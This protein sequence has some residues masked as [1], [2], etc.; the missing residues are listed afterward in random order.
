M[1]GLTKS[2][3][4]LAT[5]QVGGPGL[6]EDQMTRMNKLKT[7]LTVIMGLVL[8]APAGAAASSVTISDTTLVR[9]YIG[10]APG[11]G[12]GYDKNLLYDVIGIKGGVSGQANGFDTSAVTVDWYD[13]NSLKFTIYTNFPQ[14]GGAAI[15]S[16]DPAI[17][18]DLVLRDKNGNLYGI[19]LTTHGDFT[20]GGLY[21]NAGFLNANAQSPLNNGSWVYGGAYS[22]DGTVPATGTNLSPT[23]LDAGTLLANVSL[24]WVLNTD[25]NNA[26]T[27]QLVVDLGAVNGSGDFNQLDFFWGTGNCANDV[28]LGTAIWQGTS[29]VPVPGSVLLLGSGLVGMVL[30]RGRRRI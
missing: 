25:P 9:P 20:A 3:H 22:T 19:A 13:T 5:A 6:K 27:Y 11:S 4:G 28:I 24:S 12:A 14:G 18:A 10:T 23:L 2:I 26:G 7:W 29:A 15:E 1:I 17:A 16:G 21:Q 30:L 8:L